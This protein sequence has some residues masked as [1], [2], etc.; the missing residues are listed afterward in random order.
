MM[1][2]DSILPTIASCRISMSRLMAKGMVCPIFWL[3]FW[4]NR[5]NP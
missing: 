2:H 4:Y 3:K 5:G 1:V